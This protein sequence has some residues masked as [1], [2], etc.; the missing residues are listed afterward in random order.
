MKTS[1]YLDNFETGLLP[2]FSSSDGSGTLCLETF[3]FFNSRI[4]ADDK[5]DD[6][7]AFAS[8]EFVEVNSTNVT[9]PME[10]R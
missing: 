4:F 9:L 6:H 10:H 7:H 5:I 8:D 1:S 3:L 2:S